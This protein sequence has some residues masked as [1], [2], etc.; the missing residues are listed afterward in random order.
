MP[1]LALPLAALA[2][3]TLLAGCYDPMDIPPGPP[4]TPLPVEPAH[5]TVELWDQPDVARP[6]VEE[7]AA[8][9]WLDGT[10]GA[11]AMIVDRSSGRIVMSGETEDL[12][13]VDFIPT[14]DL[15]RIRLS[16]PIIADQARTQQLL[17]PL[18]DY[19]R[20]GEID[21]PPLPS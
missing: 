15:A 12:L 7:I 8:R 14:I 10:V 11:A 6:L 18:T 2:A 20:T 9:C 13:I 5:L 4:P 3:A 1:R 17:L 21:C 19:Q 16:G